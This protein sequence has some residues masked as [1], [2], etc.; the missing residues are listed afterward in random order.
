MQPNFPQELIGGQG[1]QR[2]PLIKEKEYTVEDFKDMQALGKE[3][4]NTYHDFCAKQGKEIAYDVFLGAV[5]YIIKQHRG[6]LSKLATMMLTVEGV[7][8]LEIEEPYAA[9]I[10]G[11]GSN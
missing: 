7:K 5:D 10:E 2:T 6:R 9:E 11:N 1:A 3:L 8:G 4:L